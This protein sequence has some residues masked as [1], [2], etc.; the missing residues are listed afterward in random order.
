[1]IQTLSVFCQQ[2][3]T[4]FW[5]CD[6]TIR[7]HDLTTT[8]LLGNGVTIEPLFYIGSPFYNENGEKIQFNSLY[9]TFFIL[10]SFLGV[11]YFKID[12]LCRYFFS[13]WSSFINFFARATLKYTWKCLLTILAAICTYLAPTFN[14]IIKLL[15]RQNSW[16]V[17][18]WALIICAL[19]HALGHEFK[20]WWQQALFSRP[21]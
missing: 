20:P 8:R 4:S 1:M 21:N 11:N 9:F 7:T 6:N 5:T 10:P 15:G 18:H 12:I 14:L 2:I 19:H 3:S 13:S 16:V 17:S